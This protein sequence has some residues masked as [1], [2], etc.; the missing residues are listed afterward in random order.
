[1]A[2][3]PKFRDP[4]IAE[5]EKIRDQNSTIKKVSNQNY[6]IAIFKSEHEIKP[7]YFFFSHVTK[8]ETCEFQIQNGKMTMNQIWVWLNTTLQNRLVR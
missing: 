7:Y 4:F 5:V 1:M 2:K 6:T 8:E 3:Q